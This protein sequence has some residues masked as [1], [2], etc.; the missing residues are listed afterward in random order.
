MTTIQ[1]KTERRDV[2]SWAFFYAFFA[3]TLA[4][5]PVILRMFEIAWPY[6]IALFYIGFLLSA[7]FS[8]LS[9]TGQRALRLLQGGIQKGAVKFAALL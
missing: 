9:P 2:E 4:T 1:V 5:M 6:K 3:A 7:W 8:L